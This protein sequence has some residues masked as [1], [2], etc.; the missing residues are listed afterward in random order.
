MPVKETT[1]VLL[2]PV[3]MVKNFLYLPAI[4]FLN[5]YAHQVTALVFLMFIDFLTGIMK[6]RKL[7]RKFTRYR[8]EI[9][10]YLKFRNILIPLLLVVVAKA[11]GYD[12]SELVKYYMVAI[13]L[14]E[15]YSILGNLYTL[16]TGKEL[17]DKDII[18]YF[19]LKLRGNID[20]SRKG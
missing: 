4:I 16:G 6:S 20:Q 3:A 5:S 17:E 7:C 12:F 15:F 13:I 8:F 1:I 18:S 2:S 19:L 10:L 9:G 11:L 14:V